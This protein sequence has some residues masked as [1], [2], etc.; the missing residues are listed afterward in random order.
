MIV[1]KYILKK[2][3]ILEDLNSD[4]LDQE[5]NTDPS[6]KQ[7]ESGNYKK[8]HIN[9][10][11]MNISIENPAGSKRKGV[12]KNGNKW[13]NTISHNYGYV[14]STLGKDHDHVD[15]FINKNFDNEDPSDQVRVFIINQ[16][17]PDTGK[18]D[19][20]KCMIGFKNKEEAKQAYLS[21]YDKSWK[22]FK[23]M[24]ETDVDTFKNWIYTKSNTKKEITDK[25]L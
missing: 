2:L 21:N 11:G 23:N 18:F 17:D 13:E 20:H 1:E 9:L 12:D 8:A 25:D 19:E 24:V 3:S 7:K 10:F 6:E 15:V 5:P 16:I 22:G 4:I 14:L